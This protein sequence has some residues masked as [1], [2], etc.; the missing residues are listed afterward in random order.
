VAQRPDA[1]AAKTQATSFTRPAAERIVKVEAGYRT[2]NALTF[3]RVGG[4]GGG[5]MVLRVATFTGAWDRGFKTVA[6]AGTTNTVEVQNLHLN[7][8]AKPGEGAEECLIGR[9]RDGSTTDWYL[10]EYDLTKRPGYIPGPVDENSGA[11]DVPYRRVFS[12]D[13]D[14]RMRWAEV[15]ECPSQISSPTAA[16]FFFGG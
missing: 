5:G 11:P 6:L 9:A 14:R 3:R 12:L 13:E 2:E 15:V 10:V 16:G 7:L 1:K 4:G 8:G